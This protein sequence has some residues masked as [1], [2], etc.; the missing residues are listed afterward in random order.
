ML[1][2]VQILM[3][4]AVADSQGKEPLFKRLKVDEIKRVLQTRVLDT[5]H[6]RHSQVPRI[7]HS[8]RGIVCYKL[9]NFCFDLE[10]F[11]ES[12]TYYK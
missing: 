7:S 2:D 9:A 11:S 8:V 12:E 3:S 6:V 5:E 1:E 10:L 4:G